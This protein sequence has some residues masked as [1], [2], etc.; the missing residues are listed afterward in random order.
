MKSHV[1][2]S[3]RLTMWFGVMFFLGWML[4]GATMW[5]NLKRTLRSERHQ[6]LTR[7]VDRL[8]ELLLRSHGADETDR[9]QVFNDFAHATGNGLA[10][11]FGSDGSR[12]YPS[13]SSAAVTFPWPT[14]RAGDSERFVH[15]QSTGQSYWVLVR[16]FSL[17]GQSLFLLAAAPESGN[18]LVLQSFWKGLL[19]SAPIL[20][21]ISSAGGY[22]VSRKALKPVDRITAAA[23]SISIRS[24]SERLPVR[25]TG[26]N[27]RG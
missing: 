27:C 20:L 16:P 19:A 4:F 13:P 17:E 11:V 2:I 5:L 3:L 21:L 24:L 14:T 7:R 1:S 12:A 25:S 22:W 23:R 9:Y 15:V 10:E 6:T 26:M 18:L 8:Q